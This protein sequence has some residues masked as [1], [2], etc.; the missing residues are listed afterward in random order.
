[1]GGEGVGAVVVVG[2][3]DVV[4]DSSNGQNG[5]ARSFLTAVKAECDPDRVEGLVAEL[6]QHELT[7][8]SRHRTN[9]ATAVLRGRRRIVHRCPW[10]GSRDIPER[11][12]G[13][14]SGSAFAEMMKPNSRAHLGLRWMYE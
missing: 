13:T 10:L 12:T 11:S 9:T 7:P 14:L 4:L 1:M 5:K 2:E 6:D 8:P 3:V